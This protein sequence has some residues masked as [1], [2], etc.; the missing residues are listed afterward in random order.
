[1]IFNDAAWSTFLFVVW[2]NFPHLRQCVLFFFYLV[3]DSTF[4]TSGRDLTRV[5]PARCVIVN[6]DFT[7]L[8]TRNIVLKIDALRRIKYGHVLKWSS[9][10]VQSPRTQFVI[11]GPFAFLFVFMILLMRRMLSNFGDYL[12]STYKHLLID[13]KFYCFNATVA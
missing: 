7:V 4:C 12:S 2:R 6:N 13:F 8:T 1:M 3:C 5:S 11:R 9:P 10:L